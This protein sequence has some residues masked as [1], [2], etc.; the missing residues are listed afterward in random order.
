[1]TT[2]PMDYT[3]LNMIPVKPYHGGGDHTWYENYRPDSTSLC[4]YITNISSGAG[5]EPEVK[6]EFNVVI[7]Y[8]PSPSMLSLVHVSTSTSDNRS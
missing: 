3:D 2:A 1:M 7:E 8:C 6:F 5:I 4:G